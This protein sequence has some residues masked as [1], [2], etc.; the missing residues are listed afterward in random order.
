MN[1]TSITFESGSSKCTASKVQP[2]W[3]LCAHQHQNNQLTTIRERVWNAVG[4]QAMHT[5]ACTTSN[6]Q[7]CASYPLSTTAALETGTHYCQP[8]G[9]IISTTSSISSALIRHQQKRRKGNG[10]GLP[11]HHKICFLLSSWLSSSFFLSIYRV[12][13]SLIECAHLSRWWVARKKI[14]GSKYN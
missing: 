7:T 10:N 11:E 12:S 2:V 6:E 14:G 9:I 4:M 13:I 3:H 1:S 8:P 5:N